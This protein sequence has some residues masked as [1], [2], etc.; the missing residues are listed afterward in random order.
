M[1][2][3]YIRVSSKEQNIARQSADI[4]SYADKKNVYVDY[5]TGSTFQRDGYQKL[6]KKL[7]KGDLLVIHSIDRLGRNYDLIIEEWS[8]ITKT[9]G[10]DI[11]VLDMPILDTRSD[12]KNLMGRFVSDIVLQILSFVAENERSNIR[13]RQAEGIQAAKANG[14]RFGRPRKILPVGYETIIKDYMENRIAFADA[15]AQLGI[16]KTSFYALIKKYRQGMLPE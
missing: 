7:N 11:L 3:G 16:G 6:L 1:V 10:C 12:N 13:K 14:V 4:Y 15:L 8:R 5:Q 9:I 2:Y